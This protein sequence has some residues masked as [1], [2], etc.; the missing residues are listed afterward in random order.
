MSSIN[1]I[2]NIY[3]I[4]AYFIYMSQKMQKDETRVAAT[5]DNALNTTQSVRIYKGNS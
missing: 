5:F 3:W 2:I 4:L 1:S